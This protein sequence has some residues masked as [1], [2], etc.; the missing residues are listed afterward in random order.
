MGKTQLNLSQEK[1]NLAPVLH[2]GLAN[3]LPKEWSSNSPGQQT[4]SPEGQESYMRVPCIFYT[5]SPG[6]HPQYP[7]SSHGRGTCGW[8][9]VWWRCLGETPAKTKER[10]KV[11]VTQRTHQYVCYN[12]ETAAFNAT[13]NHVRRAHLPRQASMKRPVISHLRC[14]YSG[15]KKLFSQFLPPSFL[16]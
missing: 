3:F 16:A 2:S 12:L 9:L 11:A 13:H 1:I 15:W 8:C 5:M 7:W 14:H 4:S 6:H 10:E